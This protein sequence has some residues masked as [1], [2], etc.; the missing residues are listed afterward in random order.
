MTSKDRLIAD[1]IA[2]M[3]QTITKAKDPTLVERFLYSLF[4][5]SEVD[6]MAK[7]WALVKDLARGMPQREIAR[8]L[9]LSLC[10]ITRGSRELKKEE[11]AFKRMLLL[12]GYEVPERFTTRR[13]PRPKR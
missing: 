2:E 12:A 13:G 1:N 10:K 5:P 7:R 6:E 11:S 3:A 4:T 8:S 9:G